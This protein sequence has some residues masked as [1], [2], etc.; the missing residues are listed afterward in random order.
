MGFLLRMSL[1]SRPQPTQRSTSSP[2]SRR[3]RLNRAPPQARH[4][5][6]EEFFCT[7]CEIFPRHAEAPLIKERPGV[8]LVAHALQV[9]AARPLATEHREVH[10]RAGEEA[11]PGPSLR[12]IDATQEGDAQSLGQREP[13]RAPRLADAKWR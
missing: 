1:M 11:E 10:E 6:I 4:S 7:G 9:D 5:L 2:G 13:A 3:L 12:A 8:G